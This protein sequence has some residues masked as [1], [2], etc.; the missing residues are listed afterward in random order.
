[1]IEIWNSYS[2]D[3]YIKEINSLFTKLH[4]SLFGLIVTIKKS[5]EN[6][7][8]FDDVRARFTNPKTYSRGIIYDVLFDFFTFSYNFLLLIK[9]FIYFVIKKIIL[10]Y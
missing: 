5:M 7:K 1:M 3:S 2:V 9:W 6:V 8:Y 4:L 10:Y